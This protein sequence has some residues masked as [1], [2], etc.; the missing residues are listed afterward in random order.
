L[1]PIPAELGLE[2]EA[3]EYMKEYVELFK[4]MDKS[5]VLAIAPYGVMVKYMKY[6][7]LN[8]V[9]HEQEKRLCW[10]AQE[11][12]YNL[13]RQLHEEMQN[14]EK[15]KIRELAGYFAPPCYKDKCI[16]G[17][18]YCGRDLK[19]VKTNKNMPKRRV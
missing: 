9:M 3:L 12:I 11:E 19:E 18:R 4:R 17:K 8:A 13:S 7:D 10:T 2:N 15:E 14:H 6:G 5:L 16:E 1:P